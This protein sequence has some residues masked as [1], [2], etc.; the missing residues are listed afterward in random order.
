VL[1]FQFPRSPTIPWHACS[2][3]SQWFILSLFFPRL[4]VAS[5]QNGIQK[6]STLFLWLFLRSEPET[7]LCAS[8]KT[9]IE[10]G[11]ELN[12]RTINKH[13]TRQIVFYLRL[14]TG[15]AGH[16]NFGS[17]VWMTLVLC[18]CAKVKWGTTCVPER[19]APM[20]NTVLSRRSSDRNGMLTT[21]PRIG[22][23]KS[24]WRR[25]SANPICL[26]GVDRVSCNWS[27]F[28]PST[29]QDARVVSPAKTLPSMQRVFS[30]FSFR[31]RQ[32]T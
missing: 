28:F 19:P 29:Q 24:E 2:S 27:T 20:G 18:M 16:R 30:V 4:L 11:N 8:P 12:T 13:D 7:E 9:E 17:W 22:E 23:V 14:E 31:H 10:R 15:M 5:C 3:I 32:H 21:L 6:T 25:T 26:L 1:C